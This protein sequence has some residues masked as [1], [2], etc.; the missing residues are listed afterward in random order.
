[1]YYV[2]GDTGSCLLCTIAYVRVMLLC[3]LGQPSQFSY[4]IIYVI[5]INIISKS[6]S[7]LEAFPHPIWSSHAF[8]IHHQVN[9]LFLLEWL[10]KIHHLLYIRFTCVIRSF[11][12]NWIPIFDGCVF[13][14]GSKNKHYKDTCLKKIELQ[15]QILVTTPHSFVDTIRRTYSSQLRN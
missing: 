13:R 11:F 10:D 4:G 1:M 7:R 6:N 15:L 9:T 3:W 2:E 8:I 5:S 14:W 12:L